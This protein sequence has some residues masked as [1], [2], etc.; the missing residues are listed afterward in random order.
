MN[1]LWLSA[2]TVAVTHPAGLFA[3]GL[4]MTAMVQTAI[5]LGRARQWYVLP[6]AFGLTALAGF[7]L[8]PFADASTALDLRVRLTSYEG[9]TS[10]CIGQ[11]LLVASALAFGL[12][13]ATGGSDD[14]GALA[15]AVVHAIPAPVVLIAMLLIEQARLAGFPGARP[16][17]VGREVGLVVASLL[18]LASAPAMLVPRRWLAGTHH[19]LSIVLL[20]ACMLV[21][22][23]QDALPRP[24]ASV[25]LESLDLL[26]KVLPVAAAVVVF[27]WFW[28]GARMHGV[29]VPST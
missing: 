20:L 28:R 24:M 23:L 10:L 8:N 2:K 11:F 9:L 27:G 18:I 15:L 13:M 16:E 26:W 1:E 7:L 29:T 17:A 5:G 14:R 4:A 19:L 21:P 12:R 3:L 6:V 25:D 22:C